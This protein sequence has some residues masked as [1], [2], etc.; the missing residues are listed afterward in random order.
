MVG[1][2]VVRQI[3]KA[4]RGTLSFETEG[5]PDG[6]SF[7]EGSQIKS[8]RLHLEHCQPAV[9]PPRDEAPDRVGSH[10]PSKGHG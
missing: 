4:T 7:C 10:I 6:P 2:D 1:K 3:R 8:C 9:N 5:Y